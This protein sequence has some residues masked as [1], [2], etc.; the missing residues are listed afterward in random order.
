[1]NTKYVYG[2]AVSDMNFDITIYYG[3]TINQNTRNDIEYDL[4]VNCSRNCK[5]RSS[6]DIYG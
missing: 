5:I 4:D 6:M 1:M 2:S 3:N